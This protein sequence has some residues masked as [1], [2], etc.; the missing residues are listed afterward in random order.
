MIAKYKLDLD[1]YGGCI[2]LNHFYITWMNKNILPW[3]KIVNG[4]FLLMFKHKRIIDIPWY[5]GNKTTS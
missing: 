2:K 5:Y 4:S 1:S 3:G